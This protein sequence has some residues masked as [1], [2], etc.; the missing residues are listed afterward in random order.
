MKCLN[1]I[2]GEIHTFFVDYD[3]NLDASKN[4]GMSYM[5]LAHCISLSKEI[6]I[7]AHIEYNG[8]LFG[9]PDNLVH[10]INNAFF[11]GARLWLVYQRF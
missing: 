8:G 10:P 11:G 7:S 6:P 1:P 5:E 4:V 3:Y 9:T 2:N